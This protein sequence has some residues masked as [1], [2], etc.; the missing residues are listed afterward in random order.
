MLPDRPA[1]VKTGTTDEYRDSWVVGY[2]PDL[3]T[4]VWV[5]NSNNSPM[6]DVLGVAGA[7]QIWHDFMAGALAGHAGRRSSSRRQGVQQAEVC[8]L[9][10]MLPTQECRENTLPI[11]G[12]RQDWFVPGIN[13]PT[14]PDDWHQRVEVCKVNGKRA[15]PLV[16]DNARDAQVFVTLPDAYRAWGLAHGYPDAADRRLQ[17][18]L[19]GRAD[20]ADRQAPTRERSDHA[21]GQTLQI[22]GSAYIDDFANYT[23]DVGAGRQP[24]HL[25]ADHRPAHAGGRQGAAR[26]VEYDG[27][28]PGRYRL[29]LRV[30][31]SFPNAQESLPL[32]VTLDRAGHADA[33]ASTD[34]GADARAGRGDPD[35]GC[36]SGHPARD[37]AS[38]TGGS[39][40]HARAADRHRRAGDARA[41]V[42]PRRQ[43]AFETAGCP[44]HLVGTLVGPRLVRQA[45]EA[46][47]QLVAAKPFVEVGS[48]R[49]I[50]LIV[51]PNG[52]RMSSSPSRRTTAARK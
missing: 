46:D 6:K 31:D 39:N 17:R 2:T 36:D 29:R 45:V 40:D 49:P 21:S 48:G 37:A 18:R 14:Q 1:A 51:L 44:G 50:W 24:D 8:A 28:Q 22:V 35:W 33:D 42:R 16:P 13:L 34:G 11:H 23:L 12:V 9:S 19:P 47:G 43:Q 5:G 30:F 4:G 20:R 10:D 41:G 3:V 27:L 25:D 26:G 32:I 7:G 15:T 38:A 52:A